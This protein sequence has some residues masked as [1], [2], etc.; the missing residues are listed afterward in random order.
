MSYSPSAAATGKEALRRR[1]GRSSWRR[2]EALW[3]YA[4][5]A[6]QVLGSLVLVVAPLIAVFYYS[7]HDW[8]V[9]ASTFDFIGLGNY[10]EIVADPAFRSSLK[11]TAIFSIGLVI[12]NMSLALV[13][14]ILLNQKLRGTLT[15]RTFFFSPVVVS[16]VA[17]SIVWGFL[18]QYDGGINGFLATFGI[19]GPNWLHTGP[20]AML[21]VIV[22]QVFKNV[23]MNMILFLAALQGV[24]PELKEAA[25]LDGAGSFR[26]F[27]SITLPGISPTVFLVSIITVIGSL[28]VFAQIAV[29]TAGGPEGSTTVLVYYLYQQAFQYN[30]FGYGSAISVILFLIVL[31]LT[32]IQWRGRKRW[33]TDEI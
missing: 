8:K 15:F 26:V 32:L 21:S 22:V 17:W 31:A 29:L 11:A 10:Q 14:A 19:Q 30:K 6:P 3:G 33:V 2:K 23:G 5:V 24:D 20:T 28:E 9:L 12:L 4:F 7:L 13:L 16:I 18:L 25:R 1:S 27:R